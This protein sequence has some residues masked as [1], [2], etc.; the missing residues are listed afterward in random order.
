MSKEP[1]HRREERSL[2]A[3]LR[4]PPGWEAVG[5]ALSTYSL[6]LTALLAVLLSLSGHGRSEESASIRATQR[7][8]LR[9]A[10]QVVVVSQRGRTTVPQT[11]GRAR[12]LAALD[13]C[14]AE[15]AFDERRH[16][17]HAKLVLAGYRPAGTRVHADLWRLWIGSRNL[18]RSL[19]LDTGVMLVGRRRSDYSGGGGTVTGLGDTLSAVLRPVAGRVPRTLFPEVR[20]VGRYPVQADPF[21]ALCRRLE[22]EVEWEAPPGV[23]VVAAAA[24]DGTNIWSDVTGPPAAHEARRSIIFAAPFVDAKGLERLAAWRRGV[25]GDR[26]TVVSSAE[27]LATLPADAVVGSELLALGREP[28]FETAADWPSA[29]EDTPAV[30]GEP[31]DEGHVGRGLHAKILLSRPLGRA[32]ATLVMGSPN[33]TRRGLVQV[34]AGGNTNMEVAL[35]LRIAPAIADAIDGALRSLT[36]SYSE[37]PRL[38][39]AEVEQARIAER[40]EAARKTVLGGF[41]AQLRINSGGLEIWAAKP[42]EVPSGFA[43]HVALQS[44]PADNRPWPPAT[45]VVLLAEGLRQDEW[46]E[47]VLFRLEEAASGQAVSWAQVI[48]LA[49]D[50]TDDWRDDRDAALAARLMSLDELHALIAAELTAEGG[51]GGR[52]WYVAGAGI[53][54]DTLEAVEMGLHLEGLLRLRARR[55]EAWSSAMTERISAILDASEADTSLSEDHRKALD[56]LRSLWR[57]VAS[58]FTPREDGTAA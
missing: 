48:P 24:S 52:T 32:K 6:D 14:L 9:L 31:R 22:R 47:L 1:F 16:S 21:A 46:T 28:D 58:A 57:I 25:P 29:D 34:G 49:L 30:D 42:P 50:P 7:A 17:W 11:R 43:L 4:P 12:V 35:R 55:P 45:S 26:L 56:R 15:Q 41:N 20:R 44:R 2:A 54:P 51:S 53:R 33:L 40:L 8:I 23:E 3:E 36:D 39:E 38:S 27:Q 5:A 19:D 10:K 18:T 37:P 13:R